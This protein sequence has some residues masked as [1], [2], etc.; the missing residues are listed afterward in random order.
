VFF[1]GRE[2]SLTLKWRMGLKHRLDLWLLL[3]IQRIGDRSILFALLDRSIVSRKNMVM[4]SLD[5]MY[6]LLAYV[7]SSPSPFCLSALRK[8]LQTSE[9]HSSKDT[10]RTQTSTLTSGHRSFAIHSIKGRSTIQRNDV[11]VSLMYE[12]PQYHLSFIQ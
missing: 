2:G 12:S 11:S 8:D 4:M 7:H 9:P 6:E 3:P 5:Y 1:H 10:T